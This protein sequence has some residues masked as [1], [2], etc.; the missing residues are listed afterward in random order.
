M[1]RCTSSPDL[2][3]WTWILVR[4]WHSKDSWFSDLKFDSTRVFFRRAETDST[5]SFSWECLVASWCDM[6]P[7]SGD[8]QWSHLGS[9]EIWVLLLGMLEWF[10]SRIDSCDQGIRQDLIDGIN[11]LGGEFMEFCPGG[12]GIKIFAHARSLWLHRLP[13]K[14]RPGCPTSL[15]TLWSA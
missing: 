1:C 14:E 7:S 10:F 12:W 6:V 11:L 8:E 3:A 2:G 5:L 4:W 9:Q 15:E 13:S